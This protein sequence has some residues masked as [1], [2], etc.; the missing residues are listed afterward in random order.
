METAADADGNVGGFATAHHE[1]NRPASVPR[2]V[3]PG[4]KLPGAIDIGM[5]DGHA[6]LVPLERL[7]TLSW[8]LDH[9]IPAVRPP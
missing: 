5:A 9:Q 4:S 3:A 6:E 1:A 2:K 8:H 7:W